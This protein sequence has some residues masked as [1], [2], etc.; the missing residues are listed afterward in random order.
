MSEISGPKQV[1]RKGQFQ[2]GQSGNPAGKPKGTRHFSTLI[3][4][5]ITA[6]S[7]D[8]GTSDDRLIVKAL[9]TKAKEGDLKA[10]DIVLDRTDGKAMQEMKIEADVTIDT[11]LTEE[12]KNQL[13]GLLK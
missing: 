4:E 5:A 6:V 9:V 11:G 1:N 2:P 8:G 3:K 10:V 12:E 13:L 7:E